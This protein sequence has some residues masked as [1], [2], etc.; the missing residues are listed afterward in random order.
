LLAALVA[1]PLLFHLA[2]VA[3]AQVP[4]VQRV[5]QLQQALAA[6]AQPHQFPGLP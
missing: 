2:A 4:L 6:L 5:N 1:Y 3:A